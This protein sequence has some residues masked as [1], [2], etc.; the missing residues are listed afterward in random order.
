MA[1]QYW[2]ASLLT[3]SDG[4]WS[5]RFLRPE[6]L[7]L[8]DAA[9]LAEIRRWTDETASS[10]RD[11]NAQLFIPADGEL[12]GWRAADMGCRGRLST[13]RVGQHYL[14]LDTARDLKWSFSTAGADYADLGWLLNRPVL[15][16]RPGSAK[17]SPVQLIQLLSE[18]ERDADTR[19]LEKFFRSDPE[20]SFQLLRLLNS[21]AFGMRTPVKS[22]G[23]AIT[24]LGRRQLQRWLQLLIYG[25]SGKSANAPN[26]LLQLAAY[27]AHLL[28]GLMRHV[29]GSVDDADAAYMTGIFSLLD[30]IIALPLGQIVRQLPLAR[31]VSAAL[32]QG[33]GL[34]GEWLALAV[35]CDRGEFSTATGILKRHAIAP[36]DWL[37]IQNAAYLWAYGLGQLGEVPA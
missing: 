32:A 28:E 6:D 36:E 1:A 2:F 11:L 20:L 14:E 4:A 8:M 3:D 34:L 29:H 15:P 35:A 33:E 12:A 5:G 37:P 17:R 26:P 23:H 13:M 22:L 19:E 16:A 24:L 31:P 10:R 21:A 27:R 7:T 18:I 9:D 25:Q 30:R